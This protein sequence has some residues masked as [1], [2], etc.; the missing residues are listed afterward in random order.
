MRGTVIARAGLLL[1]LVA[2]A[3]GCSRQPPN[4][5]NPQRGQVTPDEFAILPR[6]PLEMPANYA[7]LPPPTP[8]APNRTDIDPQADAVAAL[9]GNPAATVPD[10]RFGADGALIQQASR[11]GVDPNVRTALAAEDLRFR[12]RHRG[13]LMERLF[14][15]TTYYK[16]YGRDELDQ[17]ATTDLFRRS[18][19]PTPAMPPNSAGN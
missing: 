9:G 17:P 6:K 18:G 2:L 7:E 15:V 5:I 19:V 1:A 13:R 16:V 10:G 3:A 8:G 14:G 11:Y 12:E 4:L